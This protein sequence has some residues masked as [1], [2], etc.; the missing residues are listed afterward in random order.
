MP[1]LTGFSPTRHALPAWRDFFCLPHSRVVYPEVTDSMLSPIPRRPSPLP[2]SRALPLFFPLFFAVLITVIL[3]SATAARSQDASPVAEP[4]QGAARAEDTGRPQ[5]AFQGPPAASLAV[6]GFHL[7]TSTVGDDQGKVSVTQTRADASWSRFS[8]GWHSSWYSWEDKDLLPFGN[9]REAPW[10]G[11]HVLTFMVN[12]R[13]R[14]SPR[15]S[16]FVQGA[17]RSGFERELSRSVGVAA[18]GGLIYAWSADWTVGLG[19]FIGVDPTTRFAFSSTFAMAGPFIQ[20]RNPRAMG[21]SGRLG[22]PQS[23]LRYAVNPVWSAWLGL[24]IDSDTY[25][26]A[27][28]SAVMPRGYARSRMFTTG[29]YLDI[30]PTPALLLRLGPT[31]NFSRRLEIYDSGGDKRHSHDLDATVGFEARVSWSF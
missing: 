6:S 10:D 3:V 26:L 15:W 12:H 7:F 21:F 17:L 27:D 1:R 25:R 20:Y 8:L 29:L 16:Y 9:G 30:T 2:A 4:P 19:G 11:L 23:E 28:D 13:D 22:F 14:L 5:P 24:G 18:N 31:Y